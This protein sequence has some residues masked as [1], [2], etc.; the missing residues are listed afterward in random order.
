[1]IIHSIWE[2]HE[3][4]PGGATKAMREHLTS[5]RERVASLQN[6]TARGM[7]HANRARHDISG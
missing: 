6:S 5:L 2:E 7:W 3:K 4:W 1:M